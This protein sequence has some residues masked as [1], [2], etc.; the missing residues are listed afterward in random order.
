MANQLKVAWFNG[1]NIDKIHFEQ[2]ERYFQRNIDAKTIKVSNNLYGVVDLKFSD[3][4]LAEGKVVLERVSGIAKDGSI[5][6]APEQDLLPKALEINYESLENSIITLKIS[7]G[8]ASIADISLQNNL[9]HS[10][11]LTLRSVIASR[12]YD[13]D[14]S[15]SPQKELG[16]E[17]EL[18]DITFTQE[19]ASLTLASLR[20]KLG[21]LGSA[22]PDE[23]EIPIAKIKSID[24]NKRIELEESF[25]PTCLNISKISIVKSF[26]EG[27]LYSIK[28]H[29]EILGEIFKGIDQTKNTLDFSTYLSLNLLK[30]WFL[31]FSYLTHKDKLHPEY[32]YEKLV[33]FQGEL[34]AF[35][36]ESAFL[37]FIPYNHN[38]LN[39]TFLPLINNI[40]ILFAKITS[41]K[42]SMAKL[43]NN[44]NGFYDL[45]FDNAGILEEARLFLA[46]N[47]DVSYEYLLK[48]FKAQSKIYTQSKIKNI[49]ATQLKGLNLIQIPN[50][51]SA[52]PYLNGYVYYELD[53]KD[54]LFEHFKGENT[55]S[56]YL[57][58]NI[59]NP[60][61]KMW[62]VF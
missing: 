50:V 44:G 43:V 18:Q 12:I 17:K 62:A 6:N 29:K 45:L 42:Y 15:L 7:L 37:E 22:T 21:I 14:C 49:V 24:S 47:A 59:K 32:L 33:E 30:K 56:I 38:N 26:L 35:G 3:E 13:D 16:D 27:T 57:T 19:K 9:P 53:K 52:I 58:N 61:I 28:Q 48:N 46:I 11:Y 25:I 41:P 36:V 31:I 55:I 2:Q 39:E 20:L 51:P 5:F 1:L 8:G 40:K 23:L 10:K 4:M 54:E 60:D 34:G